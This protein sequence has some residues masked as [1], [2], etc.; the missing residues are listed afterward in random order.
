[1]FV[2]LRSHC[3]VSEGAG[4][5]FQVPRMHV[6]RWPTTGIPLTC[7]GSTFCGATPGIARPVLSAEAIP[8]LL[9]AVTWQDSEWPWSASATA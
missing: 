1:M 9:K 5:P 7:G 4:A 3:T 8:S 6:S 2:P